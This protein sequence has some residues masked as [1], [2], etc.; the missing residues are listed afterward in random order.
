MFF[1]R[2][3]LLI[4]YGVCVLYVVGIFLI[5]KRILR[6]SDSFVFDKIDKTYVSPFAEQLTGDDNNNNSNEKY[7]RYNNQ[8]NVLHFPFLFLKMLIKL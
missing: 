2:G 6:V 4:K 3:K 1:L 8:K 7:Q 5:A